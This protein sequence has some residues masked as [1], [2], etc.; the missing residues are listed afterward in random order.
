MHVKFDA[1]GKKQF[2][3]DTPL[4]GNAYSTAVGLSQKLD[5]I[6]LL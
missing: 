5:Q 3:F 4:I 2:C 1:K 6:S